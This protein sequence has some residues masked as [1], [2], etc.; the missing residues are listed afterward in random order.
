MI[1]D[2]IRI[3]CVRDVRQGGDTELSG[4]QIGPHSQQ[5]ERHLAELSARYFWSYDANGL[6]QFLWK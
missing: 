5:L 2:H 4:R 6:H 3:V 1:Q